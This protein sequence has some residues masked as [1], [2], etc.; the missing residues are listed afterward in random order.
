MSAEIIAL[1]QEELS[2][3]MGLIEE[4]A[5]FDELIQTYSQA[6]Y[7]TT[8]EPISFDTAMPGCVDVCAVSMLFSP[9]FVEAAL[10]LDVVGDISEP[11]LDT[12]G[13]HILTY[14]GDRP[15]G[16]L[17]MNDIIQYSIQRTI[18]AERQEAAVAA[19]WDAAVDVVYTGPLPAPDMRGSV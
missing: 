4:G 18:V 11:F 7:V 16:P 10:A 6:A 19:W 2:E 14:V 5:D 17:P 9:T 3:I 1:A 12:E 13:V 15:E 8:G